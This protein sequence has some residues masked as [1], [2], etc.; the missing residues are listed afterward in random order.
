MLDACPHHHDETDATESA[1]AKPT[2][3]RSIDEWS[4]TPEFQT[5]LH[6]EFPH[7]ASE[8]KDSTSRR[9]FM[10][11][12]GASAALAGLS[13]CWRKPDE[14]IVPFVEAPEQ[15]VPGVE[16]YF[17]TAVPFQGYARGALVRSNEGRPTK[18]EGNPEHPASLG[19]TDLFAQASLLTMYDP[20]RSQAV[21]KQG[22]I[23]SWGNFIAMLA[24]KMDQAGDSPLPADGA[25]MRIVSRSF[26]SPTLARQRSLFLAK[27]PAARWHHYQPISDAIASMVPRSPSRVRPMRC[28]VLRRRRSSSRWI[29]TSS[30]AAPHRFAWAASSSTVGEFAK[31]ARRTTRR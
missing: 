8:W 3:W 12:M 13:G 16:M 5:M 10:K 20:D 9:T 31:T 18:I 11:L 27:Y 17:A 7:A 21:T 26:T 4:N 1:P 24:R 23:S 30:S 29:A 15:M 2:Y 28:T 6:R 25:G 22:E 19:A 14:H